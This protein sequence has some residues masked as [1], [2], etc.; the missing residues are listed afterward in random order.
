MKELKS[1]INEP[2]KSYEIGSKERSSLQKRYDELASNEIEI[3]IIING[4]KILTDDTGKCVMPHDHQYILAKYHKADK[5]LALQAI[6]SSLE[7]WTDW[8]KTDLSYRIDIFRRAATLLAGKWRDTINAATMLNQ[9]KNAFQA[10]ID[11]ACELI[12]FFN[13]NTL[14]AKNIHNKQELIS[15]TGMKNSLEY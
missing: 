15:P 2:V 10:E 3:P 11:S 1:L 8:S 9:S 5:N 4:E 13:F 14:Y 6:E 7:A 12:D